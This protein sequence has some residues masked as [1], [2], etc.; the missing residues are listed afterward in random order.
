MKLVTSGYLLRLFKEHD[1]NTSLTRP[2]IRL[3]AQ[4]YGIFY[5][6]HEKAWLID[7]DAFMKTI[8]PKECHT[9]NGI[10]RI[11]RINEAVKIYNE[12]HSKQINRE[13]IEQYLNSGKI[14]YYRYAN[15]IILNYDELEKQLKRYYN[16]KRKKK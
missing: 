1:K 10:S 5:E 12:S 2:N 13:K 8:I 16:R 4:R 11:R 6:A 3:F 14:S 9:V 7:F 15:E